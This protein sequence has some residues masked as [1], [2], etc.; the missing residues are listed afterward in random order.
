MNL[1]KNIDNQNAKFTLH[2]VCNMIVVE[3]IYSY[4]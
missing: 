2:M 3:C 1:E 4:L